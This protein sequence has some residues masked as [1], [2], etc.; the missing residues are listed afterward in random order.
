MYWVSN[1]LS[2]KPSLHN[3]EFFQKIQPRLRDQVD[4]LAKITSAKT[5]ETAVIL[6]ENKIPSFW[7]CRHE[8]VI[9][10]GMDN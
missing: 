6:K 7:I 3:I 1:E 5:N 8:I 4:E 2:L 10:T 9:Y